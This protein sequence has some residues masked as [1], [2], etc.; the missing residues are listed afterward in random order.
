MVTIIKKWGNTLALPIPGV[1]AKALR[2]QQGSL[3]VVS[4]VEGKMII[5]P[6]R[7]SKISLSQML[8]GITKNN[9]HSGQDGGGAVG[10]EVF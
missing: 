10:R 6:I 2:L 1:I 4:I 5:K 8:K 7:E 3:V 9:R